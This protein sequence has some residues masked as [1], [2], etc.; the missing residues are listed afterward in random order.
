M[1]KNRVTFADGGSLFFFRTL[2][3]IQLYI[4][5]HSGESRL[6]AVLFNLCF[7]KESWLM[8]YSILWRFFKLFNISPRNERRFITNIRNTHKL[9]LLYMF[10]YLCCLIRIFYYSS[11]ISPQRLL[12]CWREARM[13]TNSTR[14]NVLRFTWQSIRDIRMSWKR[15]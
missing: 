6:K 8:S 11:E 3:E 2:K 15:C 5:L 1:L 13:A 9:L 14:T 12:L 10:R 7:F 4:M